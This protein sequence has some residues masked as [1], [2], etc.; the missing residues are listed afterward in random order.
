MGH[1][2][3]LKRFPSDVSF[4]ALD[5]ISGKSVPVLVAI[6]RLPLDQNLVGNVLMLGAVA[7]A[8]YSVYGFLPLPQRDPLV[9]ANALVQNCA[10]LFFSLSL[11]LSISRGIHYERGVALSVVPAFC[12]V[13]Q[14]FP[15]YT[16]DAAYVIAFLLVFAV[17]PYCLS[18]SAQ[19]DPSSSVGNALLFWAQGYQSDEEEAQGVLAVLWRCLQLFVLAFYACIQHAPPPSQECAKRLSSAS[20]YALIASLVAAWLRVG[21]WYCVCFF[22]NNAMHL[23]LENSRGRWDWGACMGY[24]VVL[25]YSACWNATVIREQLLAPIGLT[26]QVARLKLLVCVLGLATLFRQRNPEDI[27]F[28]GTGGLTLLCLLLTAAVLTPFDGDTLVARFH[29][30]FQA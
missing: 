28:W 1:A 2:D 7:G 18:V 23:M 14:P 16:R 4:L 27:L 6:A 9:I 13:A 30:Q 15:V 26:S 11:A 10:A 24:T 25:L 8:F 19:A 12:L 22:Q 20:R 21:A 29:A 17:L 3:L 5:L